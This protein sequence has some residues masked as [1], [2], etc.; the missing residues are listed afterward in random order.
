MLE[1]NNYLDAVRELTSRIGAI[2]RGVISR[3]PILTAVVLVFLAGGIALI[4]VGGS[5]KIV[6]GATSILVA[7][8]LTW[9]GLGTTAGKL[10]GKLEQPLWGAVLDDPIADAITLLPATKTKGLGRR[11]VAID[12]SHQRESQ[13]A[14]NLTPNREPE[15]VTT[16]TP[17]LSAPLQ[18]TANQQSAEEPDDASSTWRVSV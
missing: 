16:T 11:Q 5:S 1:I 7:F 4:A 17:K 10:V 18:A 15:P 6:G 3:M 12:A 2:A 13:R 14:A 8:G 9:R